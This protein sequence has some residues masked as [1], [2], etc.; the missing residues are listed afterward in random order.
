MA[1]ALLAFCSVPRSEDSVAA[2]FGPDGRRLYRGLADAGL[3]LDPDEAAQ[4][5]QMFSNFGAFDI[6]RRMLADSARI[7]A[8]AAALRE[9]VKPGMTVLDAGTGSGVLACLAAAAGAERVFGVDNSDMLGVAEQ[10]VESSGWADRITLVRG[11]FR[12]V[13]LPC[14]VDVIVTETFGAVAL[15]EG[16][17]PDIAACRARH[18]TPDGVMIPNRVDLFAALVRSEALYDDSVTDI[19]DRPGVDLTVMRNRALGSARS[20]AIGADALASPAQQFASLAYPD[21]ASAAR[22]TLALQGAAGTVHGVATWFDLVLSPSV[23]LSTGPEA[24]A[25]HWRQTYLPMAPFDITDDAVA[26]A[27]DVAPAPDDRR[28][29]TIDCEVGHGDTARR[30][31]HRVR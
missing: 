9:V 19:S 10:V 14:P 22:G 20:V 25:T 31:S 6:H 24:P 1:V 16:S 5:P 26:L 30:T 11:D 13:D 23:T 17:A 27:I 21:E 29:L 7:E 28:A 4:T 2:A 18:L 15:A 8:Y 3:L 12:T